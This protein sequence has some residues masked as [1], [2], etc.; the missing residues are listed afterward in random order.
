MPEAAGPS[1]DFFAHGI[2]SITRAGERT[3]PDVPELPHLSR[4]APV[5]Q[6]QSAALTPLLGGNWLDSCINESIQPRIDDPGVLFPNR[7]SQAIESVCSTL[8]QASERHGNPG[9]LDRAEKVL[10][11]QLEL[12]EIARIF[13]NALHQA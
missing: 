4:L 2:E 10:A 1:R 6:P 11:E 7:F 9:V 3:D 12:R 8:K 5:H 13:R